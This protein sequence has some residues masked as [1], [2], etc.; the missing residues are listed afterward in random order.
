M[1]EQYLEDYV[2]MLYERQNNGAT[3]EQSGLYTKADYYKLLKPVVDLVGTYKDYS[4]S[5][6]RD[7]LYQDS[8]IEENVKELVGKK[9]MTPGMVF[10]YGTNN[11]RETV[12]IGNKAEIIADD[13]GNLVPCIEKMTED[14]IFDLASVTKIFTSLS[15]MKLVQ[16]GIIN[17]NDEI[18]RYE[19]RFKNLNGVTIFDLMSFRVP[20]STDGRIDN[21]S[22]M[23]NAEDILFTM[24]RNENFKY[25][26]NPY[27]DL[28]AIVLKYVIE[29][30][31]GISY[32]KFVDQNILSKL[33]MNDT[34]VL[35]PKEKL[36]RVASTNIE[37]V[38]YN[39][40]N[41]V[42]IPN[43]SIGVVHDPKAQS[44]GQPQGILSGHAGMFSTAKDMTNLSKEIMNGQIIDKDYVEEIAKNRTG[45][46][47]IK[48]GKEAYI[49][50]LGF[51]CYS[52]NPILANSELFHAM[53][54]KAFSNG[55]YTGTQLTVDPINQIYLFLGSNRTHNRVSRVDPSQRK[56]INYDEFG[57]GTILLPN[58]KVKTTSYNF[59]WDRDPAVVHPALKLAIQYKMLED[60]Y[61]LK[62][63]INDDKVV[64]VIK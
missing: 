4:I 11:Y 6:L 22:S 19:P 17:I 49:Q 1:L 30:A 51:L 20:L 21:S 42:D 60:L 54:G 28:G 48:D 3:L 39:D 37:T 55:G 8:N 27:T 16:E 64:R 40:G 31:S 58:G 13:N 44:L 57:K 38:Y 26:A 45:E 53:S 10:S 59:A 62:P 32:Y 2:N 47:Y 35:V 7:K 23:E 61:E 9:E 33:K 18:V 29:N 63:K 46:K 5:E 56:N 24:H 12:V 43:N 34:H 50:Y 36:G 41:I 25:G 15:I 14:T 52:K